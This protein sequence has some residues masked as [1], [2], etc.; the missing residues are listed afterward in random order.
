M[1][2]LIRADTRIVNQKRKTLWRQET[3]GFNQVLPSP[4]AGPRSTRASLGIAGKWEA[5]ESNFFSDISERGTDHERLLTLG[6]KQGVV[7]GEEGGGTE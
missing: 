7:E 5:V 3:Q 2:I 6:N 4:A 1:L